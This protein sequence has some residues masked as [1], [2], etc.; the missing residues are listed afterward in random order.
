M[1]FN[2]IWQM[3]Q[4]KLIVPIGKVSSECNVNA[5]LV[6]DVRLFKEIHESQDGVFIVT[7]ILFQLFAHLGQIA[8]QLK[9]I[10]VVE[11]NQI[12]GFTF[13]QIQ[14]IGHLFAEITERL[15]EYFWH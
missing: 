8:A 15:F 6:M 9:L 2:E 11:M 14:M 10:T 1:Q 13:Q 7:F 3:L 12:I 4:L 5:A